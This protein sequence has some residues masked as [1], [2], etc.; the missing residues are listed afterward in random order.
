MGNTGAFQRSN[1]I[2][3]RPNPTE[4]ELNERFGDWSP[5]ILIDNTT[6]ANL[7]VNVPEFVSMS[8]DGIKKIEVHIVDEHG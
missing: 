7:A 3:A 1:P 4:S 5:P 8:A 6:V 2:L